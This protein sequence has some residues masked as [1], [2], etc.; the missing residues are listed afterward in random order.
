MVSNAAVGLHVLNVPFQNNVSLGMR[1]ADW[2]GHDD[3]IR[4]TI[5][6]T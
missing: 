2:Q 3:T 1:A 4:I 5:H 6:L